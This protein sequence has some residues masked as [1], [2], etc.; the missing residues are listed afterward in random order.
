MCLLVSHSYFALILFTIAYDLNEFHYSVHYITQYPL[1]VYATFIHK[2]EF[3]WMAVRCTFF[4]EAPPRGHSISSM[5]ATREVVAF[6]YTLLREDSRRCS[7]NL[8]VNLQGWRP[9]RNIR[10][11]RNSDA[12]RRSG[13]SSVFH[14]VIVQ[15]DWNF[16]IWLMFGWPIR[17]VRGEHAYNL[18]FIK[19]YC[20]YK[21]YGEFICKLKKNN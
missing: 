4:D 2:F 8:H 5:K 20:L 16:N 21:L 15:I 3:V 1:Y 14:L 11:H 9:L 12:A 18:L 6:R 19:K 17:Y 13:G 10:Q 7:G